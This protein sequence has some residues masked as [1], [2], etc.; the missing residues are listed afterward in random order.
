MDDLFGVTQLSKTIDDEKFGH[1]TSA[2]NN[3]SA[4]LGENQQKSV[5]N[6]RAAQSEKIPQT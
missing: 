2:G 3:N 5:S 1:K 4:E 6:S